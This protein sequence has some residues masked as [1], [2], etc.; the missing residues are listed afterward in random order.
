MV[1][2]TG[3]LS[4]RAILRAARELRACAW[5][6]EAGL[7][8]L[9][10]GSALALGCVHPWAY[11]PAFWLTGVLVALGVRRASLVASL[12]RRIGPRRFCFHPSGLWLILDEESAYGLRTWSCDLGR[13]SVPWSALFVPGALFAAWVALQLLLLPPG[14]VAWLSPSPANGA[15]SGWL[16]LSASVADT[17]RG[18]AFVVFALAV[19]ALALGVLDTPAARERFRRGAA[20]F[21]L[22]L[23]LFAL[24]QAAT[25]TERVYGVFRPLDWA[26]G[27]R[28]LFGP[29]VNRNHFAAWANLLIPLAMGLLA[30]DGA[31]YLRR[32]GP[33]A[34]LRRFLVSLQSPEGARAVFALAPPLAAVAALLASGSRGGLLAFLGGLVVVALVHG[35]RRPALL[36][37]LAFVALALAWYGTG[38][39]VARFRL[40]PAEAPGR[41]LVWRDA[42]ARVPV[43]WIAGSG[44]NT[45]STAVSRATLWTLPAGATPWRAPYETSVAQAPRL[46]YR[47][48]PGT[49]LLT[50][51][52][53]AHNDYL[54]VLIETGAPGLALS[55]LGLAALLRRARGDPWV[56]WG[57]AAV[58]LHALV[59]FPLQIPAVA[60]LFVSLAAL[61]GDD[62]TDADARRARSAS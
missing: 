14:L 22:A 43:Y 51:S 16:P 26:P 48:L 25:G 23:S 28:T 54:Q 46:G 19:H 20:G 50:W 32:V 12:R 60:A 47:S 42:L 24:V 17:R 36:L 55:L 21:V 9:L 29:F 58:A 62:Y 13:P 40:T 27:T 7:Y 4:D 6:L 15:P 8:V 59:D 35:R 38:R 52:P 56:L 10:A 39:V 11:V 61:R 31:R 44:F 41:T 1:S 30:Q 18:L 49:P 45:F 53:E 5:A 57:L 37:P 2:P 33:R 34:N 3:A